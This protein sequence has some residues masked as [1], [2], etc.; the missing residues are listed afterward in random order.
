M[1][2]TITYKVHK[3]YTWKS[4]YIILNARTSTFCASWLVRLMINVS[5][6][7][8]IKCNIKVVSRI[9]YMIWKEL[10]QENKNLKLYDLSRM[11]I[12]KT[13]KINKCHKIEYII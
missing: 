9:S 10:T 3:D 11:L 1:K 13:S 4:Q 8:Q 6:T 2:Y 7:M 5:C 12:K